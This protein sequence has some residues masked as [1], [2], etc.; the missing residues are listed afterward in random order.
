MLAILGCKEGLGLLKPWS[1]GFLIHG[2]S[3]NMQKSSGTGK[4]AGKR[5]KRNSSPQATGVE[6]L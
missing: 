2:L 4:D 5:H 6:H 3:M 1:N